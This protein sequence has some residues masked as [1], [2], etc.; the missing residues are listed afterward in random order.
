M[1]EEGLALG[2]LHV[3]SGPLVRTSYHARDQVPDAARR[4]AERSVATRL[5]GAG[6]PAGADRGGRVLSVATV[7]AEGRVVP[8]RA[9]A[10]E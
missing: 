2:F 1:R 9:P 4:A 5:A 10:T 7:D 3:E 8:A 6:P